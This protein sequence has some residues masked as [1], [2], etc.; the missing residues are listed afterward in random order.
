MRTSVELFYT[1]SIQ[2]PP[3][4]RTSLEQ[5]LSRNG[6]DLSPIYDP[7]FAGLPPTK[8]L[9]KRNY[10]FT[11]ALLADD[12]TLLELSSSQ[13][14]TLLVLCVQHRTP[15]DE[16]ASYT[17]PDLQ[18]LSWSV[19]LALLRSMLQERFT[20][21]QQRFPASSW[22]WEEPESPYR[23]EARLFQVKWLRANIVGASQACRAY[24]AAENQLP[25]KDKSEIYAIV[26]VAIDYFE[27]SS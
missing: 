1:G 24:A 3:S 9:E 20:L 6:L 11:Y 19:R 4:T 10:S 17:G 12:R 18:A 26:R 23:Y 21:D 5:A 15:M 7:T 22:I 8:L 14:P 16:W 2:F 25:V 13:A 27:N